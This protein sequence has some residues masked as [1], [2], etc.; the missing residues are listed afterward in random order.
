VPTI[1]TSPIPYP[2]AVGARHSFASIRAII[3]GQT[4]LGIKTVNYDRVRTREK[5][6][7]THVDPLGKTVGDNEYTCTIDLYLAEWNQLQQAIQLQALS[8]G[9]GYGDLFFNIQVQYQAT[10]FAIIQDS[11]VG[12]TL[13][14]TT[15]SQTVGPSGLVRGI[16]L[17]PI[18]ILFN[19]VDDYFPSLQ[20][21]PT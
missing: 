14:K 5:I 16:E 10:N 2:D 13:D 8:A 11:I 12:C 7:G 4:F 9:V 1:T 20:G 3:A 17:N 15:A 19:G 21:P 18:K 6:K